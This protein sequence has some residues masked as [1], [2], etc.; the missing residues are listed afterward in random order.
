MLDLYT[1]FEAV[2]EALET[3]QINY[4][5]CGGLAV[6]LLAQPRLTQ[7]ID[8]L[9]HPDDCDRSKAILLPLGFKFFSAPMRFDNDIVE[10]HKL[11]KI[12]IGGNDYLFLDLVVAISPFSQEILRERIRL[13]WRNKQIWVVSREGLIKLKESAKRPQDLLDL[14]ALRETQ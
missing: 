12:E 9:V 11:T 4:A 2:L 8:I 6:T 13:S 3:H 5:V 1:E 10:V 14:E 7:D